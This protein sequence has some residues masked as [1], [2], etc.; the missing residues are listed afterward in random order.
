VRVTPQS[1]RG[2][3]NGKKVGEVD[4]S[5]L[6]AK[7]L[8]RFRDLLPGPFPKVLPPGDLK[9]APKGPAPEFRPLLGLYV[10]SGTALFRDVE[11]EPLNEDQ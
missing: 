4:P 9:L 6:G 2:L 5:E 1:I 11:I 10:R 7:A 8:S 3:W